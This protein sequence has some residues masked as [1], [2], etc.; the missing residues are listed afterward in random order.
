MAIQPYGTQVRKINLNSLFL[1]NNFDGLVDGCNRKIASNH[2][3]TLNIE[4]Y[5]TVMTCF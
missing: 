5:E 3:T 1:N 2:E 4:S